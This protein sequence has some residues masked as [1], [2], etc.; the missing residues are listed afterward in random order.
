LVSVSRSDLDLRS[1]QR[2]GSDH[3]F[4]GSRLPTFQ[5][6]W[7]SRRGL[8]VGRV[9]SWLHVLAVISSSGSVEIFLLEYTSR[10]RRL[11]VTAGATIHPLRDVKSSSGLL[12]PVGGPSR[13][14]ESGVGVV[15][16]RH[17][18][19]RG[20]VR[21]V[22]FSSNVMYRTLNPLDIPSQSVPALRR[23][24]SIGSVLTPRCVISMGRDVDALGSTPGDCDV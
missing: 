7:V 21:P 17:R 1:L 10:H 2:G 12:I 4:R 14:P 23:S 22:L 6:D 19:Q 13:S 24:A 11:L 16:P 18:P 20:D 8:R 9:R 3:I 15:S 5:A